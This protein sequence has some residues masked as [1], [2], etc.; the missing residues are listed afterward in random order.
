MKI[1]ILSWNVRG[2]GSNARRL[3]WDL[4]ARVK[5]EVVILQETKLEFANRDV[6]SSLCHFHNL[7][8]TVLPSVG[9]SGG[10]LMFW[11]G[12]EVV[13]E[14]T[15]VD[16]FSVSLVAAVK[17]DTYKWV[18][19]GV[20]GP[21]SGDRLRD[22]INELQFIRVRKELPWCIGGDFNEVLY[23]E[24]RNRAIR[25]TRGMKEFCE[26]VD[27]NDLINIPMT[28]ARFT[29]SNSQE[30]S[31]LSKLDR[32]LISIEWEEYFDSVIV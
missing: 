18:L 3:V 28:W 15:W 1:N 32:F 25:R 2:L 10:I 31:S 16:N 13:C 14:D 12:E 20:Y 8:W 11:N 22:F 5:L 7:E 30:R 6:V 29:W 4:V 24:E 17:G 9:A 19:T 27:G 21:T 26:F 23:M